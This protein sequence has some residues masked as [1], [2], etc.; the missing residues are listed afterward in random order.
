LDGAGLTDLNT[1]YLNGYHPHEE[2]PPL[3]DISPVSPTFLYSKRVIAFDSDNSMAHSYDVLR[4]QLLNE[5]KDRETR[6][7]SVTAP[8]IGCGTTVTAVN[9]A[10]SFARIPGANVLL[11]DANSRDPSIG[12]ILGLSSE[13]PVEDPIRGWLTTVDIRGL[14]SHLLRAAWGTGKIPL[15]ADLARMT[16]QVEFAR[17]M[18]KPTIVL[19]DLPP[20]LSSDEVIPFVDMSDT[21]VIVL[22][23]GKSRLPELEICRSY[24]GS[25][26]SM[27]VVLNKTKRHGL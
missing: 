8:T 12:N 13:P 17:Q 4:N 10:L 3:L 7:I 25:E 5:H 2:C 11:V 22:A 6:V 14:R 24:L 1:G 19:F 15:P 16:A 21:A 9:L 20:M 26:K 23:I 18:L 27:Q